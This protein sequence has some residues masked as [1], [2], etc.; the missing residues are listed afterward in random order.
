MLH[1]IR[2]GAAAAFEYHVAGPYLDAARNTV[3]HGFLR[4]T[5]CDWLLF[6]DSDIGFDGDQ[7]RELVDDVDPY[8]TPVVGGLYMNPTQGH[9]KPVAYTEST[10]TIT[11]Y[12]GVEVE[13]VHFDQIDLPAVDAPDMVVDAIGTG[14]MAIHRSLLEKMADHFD[15]PREWFACEVQDG[16]LLGE[17]LAFCRRVRSLG[18]PIVLNPRVRLAH[19]KDILLTPDNFKERA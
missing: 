4:D 16:T 11:T 14:F 8:V 19:L 2:T 12:G 15:H 1:A 18:Y 7:I 17:D 9:V 13:A 6:I 5:D 3:V 10:T